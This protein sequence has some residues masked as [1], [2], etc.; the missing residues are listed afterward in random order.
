MISTFAVAPRQA[1]ADDRVV[2]RRRAPWPARQPVELGLE[3]DRHGRRRLA[4]LVAEQRHRHRPAVVDA[5]DDVR[6]SGSAASVKKTSLNSH[7]PEIILIGRTSTPGWPSSTSRNEMPL[8]FGAS[9]SVRASRKMWSARWPADVQIFWPLMHPLVAVEHGPAAEVAE[10]GAGVRL[11]VALAPDVLAGEDAREVVRA[12]ARR[13]PTAGTC[14]RA[15]GCRTRRSAPPVGHAGL[16]EL[17]GEDHLLER[18]TARRRRT[19]SASRAR[20][21]PCS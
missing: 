10:V 7:S 6:P 13:C 5:A 2:G 20:G 19:P 11:G 12:S 3:A 8:C 17:L 18:A 14:C 16:G 4:P 15:S 9:G 1:L 21:S